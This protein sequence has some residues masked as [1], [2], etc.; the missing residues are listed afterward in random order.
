MSIGFNMT[1]GEGFVPTRPPHSLLSLRAAYTVGI[2]EEQVTLIFGRIPVDE[3]SKLAKSF[4]KST[5]MDARLSTYARATMAI[6]DSANLNA[7]MA[8]LVN[9][10]YGEMVANTVRAANPL[11]PEGAVQW[12]RQGEVGSSSLAMLQ[13]AYGDNGFFEFRNGWDAPRSAADFL[14]C[15]ALAEA[16]P[17]ARPSMSGPLPGKNESWV[18]V[19]EH[20]DELVALKSDPV[21]LKHHFECIRESGLMERPSSRGG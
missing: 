2:T 3:M 13:A 11:M 21:A 4:K 7:C 9:G 18:P 17:G 1:V 6:G 19:I 8:R 5:L 12:L 14:R 15:A 20:W 16:V 10:P